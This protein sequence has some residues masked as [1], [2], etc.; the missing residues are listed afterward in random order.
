MNLPLTH[1]RDEIVDGISILIAT[2][3][4]RSAT[5]AARELGTRLFDRTHA[6]L[7]PTTALDL[8]LPTYFIAPHLA[9]F[10]R[11]FAKIV[12]DIAAVAASWGLVSRRL[13]SIKMGMVCSSDL[14]YRIQATHSLTALFP[15]GALASHA[16]GAHVPGDQPDAATGA[17]HCRRVGW[18]GIH[19]E[20][21]LLPA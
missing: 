2:S 7:I 6:G 8:I 4:H 10:Q 3:K 11:Q 19:S 13:P 1:T 20:R 17:T 12:L 15:A 14:A 21:R 18:A 16:L 5:K 9:A